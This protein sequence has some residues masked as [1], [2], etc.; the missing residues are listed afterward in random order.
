M[1][2]VSCNVWSLSSFLGDILDI[3]AECGPITK[4]ML[5]CHKL[6][7]TYFLFETYIT[8][9]KLFLGCGISQ[10]VSYQSH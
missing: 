10:L 3:A 7:R 6:Q 1:V 5:I 9:I 4:L 8:K 2:A